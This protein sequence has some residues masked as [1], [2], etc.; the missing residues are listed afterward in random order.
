M[1]IEL[2]K[3]ELGVCLA[4]ALSS[5]SGGTW[6]EGVRVYRLGLPPRRLVALLPSQYRRQE[7]FATLLDRI[8]ETAAQFSPPPMLPPPP[9]LA[10]AA[11]LAV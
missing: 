10:G 4:P 3:A 5:V 2:V 7:P 8:A 11:D 1:A 9:F 6:P